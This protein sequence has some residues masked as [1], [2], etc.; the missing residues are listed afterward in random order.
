MAEF[1]AQFP[2][3]HAA[4]QAGH[5]T[6]MVEGAETPAEVAA[7]MVPALRELAAATAPGATTVVVAHG[8]CLKVALAGLLGW[9]E[10]V[11]GTLGGLANGGWIV[12]EDAHDGRGLRLSAYNQTSGVVNTDPDFTSDSPVG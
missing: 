8:A 6:G 2:E 9:P 5:I 12:L 1:A 4:W 7:R 3:A 10:E 11:V